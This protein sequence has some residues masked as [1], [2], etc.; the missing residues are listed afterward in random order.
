MEGSSLVTVASFRDPWE[1]HIVRGRLE[2]EE[3]PVFLAHENHIWLQWQISLALG[4]VKLQVPE[5]SRESAR[6]ILTAL[7]TG[8][9]ADLLDDYEPVFDAGPCP[10]CASTNPVPMF[11]I[12]D[13]ISLVILFIFFGLTY[14][15]QRSWNFCRNCHHIWNRDLEA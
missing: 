4:G 14:P 11:S 2:A 15:A 13:W 9:Y 1:A 10:R 12:R 6:A 3:I 5:S 7:E 8:E